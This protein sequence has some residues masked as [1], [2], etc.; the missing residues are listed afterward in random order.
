M[1]SRTDIRAEQRREE[2]ENVRKKLD[3]IKEMT[4][5]TV[6]KIRRLEA[7]YVE[8]KAKYTK[9]IQSMRILE[10]NQEAR[11]GRLETDIYLLEQRQV[12]L[13][14]IEDANAKLRVEIEEAMNETNIY[15]KQI[16]DIEE[17]IKKAYLEWEACRDNELM[18]E[19][20]VNLKKLDNDPTENEGMM[21]E[22]WHAVKLKQKE[23]KKQ[24]EK[25]DQEIVDVEWQVEKQKKVLTKLKNAE[26]DLQERYN[27]LKEEPIEE[28]PE[29]EDG[30][31]SRIDYVE[32]VR[33]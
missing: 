16:D 31:L 18:L 8:E 14:T 3:A 30:T 22:K 26:K 33:Q 19:V 25:V 23:L 27:S 7:E 21:E 13:V 20:G 29:T 12:D 10:E 15:S 9:N 1:N 24:V 17:E 6:D 28:P 11:R 2:M 32:D 4:R 5:Q